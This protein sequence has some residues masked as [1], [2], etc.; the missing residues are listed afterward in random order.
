M[1]MKILFLEDHMFYANEILEYLRQDLKHEVDY[2]D[3]WRDAE[4]YMDKGNHY[5]VTLLD[6]ILKNGKTG[7]LFAE[8]WEP[9]LGRIL[10]ITGCSDETTINAVNKWSA[11][12]KMELIWPPLN[13]FIAGK[14]LKIIK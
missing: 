1:I 13:D 6:V 9:Y 14:T 3:S 11:V 10:F 5:D 7:V 4:A 8:K 12:S 2:A